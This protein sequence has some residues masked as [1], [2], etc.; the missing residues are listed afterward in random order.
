MTLFQILKY[1]PQQVFWPMDCKHVAVVD[2]WWSLIL[3][4]SMKIRNANVV[5][6]IVSFKQMVFTK[7]QHNGIVV[8]C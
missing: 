6:F 2:R 8:L 3:N 7:E 5:E 1:S 4:F